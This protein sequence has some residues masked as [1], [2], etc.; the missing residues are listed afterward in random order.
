LPPSSS[1]KSSQASIKQVS[2]F[3]IHLF[4]CTTCSSMLS[5]KAICSSETSVNCH[6][7]SRRHIPEDHTLHS[8]RRENL[9]FHVLPPVLE[10]SVSTPV[11]SLCTCCTIFPEKMTVTRTVNIFCFYEIRRLI[12]VSTK[13]RHWT[14]SRVS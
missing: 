4:A 5:I 2:L 13:A 1:S 9:R 8:H 3:A 11:S 6:Q 7:A 12:P 14:L 10:T